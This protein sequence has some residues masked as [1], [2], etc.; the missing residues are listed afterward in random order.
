LK[1]SIVLKYFTGL[2]GLYVAHDAFQLQGE[3]SPKE[4]YGE[5][6]AFVACETLSV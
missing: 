4:L 2:K 5:L 1:L 6:I 3:I